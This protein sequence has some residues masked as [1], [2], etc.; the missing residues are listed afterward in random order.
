MDH[1][2]DS[3]R[4]SVYLHRGA[5]RFRHYL[6]PTNI[7]STAL[8]VHF[9]PVFEKLS[10]LHYSSVWKRHGR[11]NL[12]SGWTMAV[13][14]T[15]WI[16]FSIRLFSPWIVCHHHLALGGRPDGE[17]VTLLA[18]THRHLWKGGGQH[19]KLCNG[20]PTEE[21]AFFP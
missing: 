18:A 6:S 17:L 9:N 20:C 3:I 13:E 14:R 11:R 7:E 4:C 1:V 2:W 8:V 16:T 19:A 10:V 15:I 12:S 21:V 5:L